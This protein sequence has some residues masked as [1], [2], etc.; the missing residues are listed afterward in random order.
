MAEESLIPERDDV[1]SKHV[2]ISFLHVA[3]NSASIMASRVI[4]FL[5]VI[6]L[7][8]LIARYLSVESFGQL[9]FVMAISIILAP[10]FDLG[11][12]AIVIREIVRNNY[13]AG[14]LIGTILVSKFLLLFLVTAILSIIIYLLNWGENIVIAVFLS[15]FTQSILSYGQLFISVI[16]AFEEM[17]YEIVVNTVHNLILILSTLVVIKYDLGFVP[18]FIASFIGSLSQIIC[19][20]WIVIQKFVVPKFKGI[21]KD[22]ILYYFMEALPLAIFAV[23]LTFAFQVDIF[24]LNAFKGPKDIAMFELAHR[25]VIQLQVIPIAI[26]SSLLPGFTRIANK[27]LD[28]LRAVFLKVIQLLLMISLPLSVLLMFG[29]D[30]IIYNMFG[31][32]Y[33]EAGISLRILAPSLIP[34]FLMYPQGFLL[35]S[36]GKQ[37]LASLSAF[38]C[39]IVNL[40]LDIILIPK[41][42]YIGA[43]ISTAIS[44]SIFF[45]SASYFVFKIIGKIPIWEVIYK[46]LASSIFMGI[47]CYLIIKN[48]NILQLIIGGSLG[49][50]VYV[51]SI[52]IL[53]SKLRN[54]Y[55][56]IE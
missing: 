46:P 26:A 29:S 52:I 35:T 32:K 8:V 45:I 39:F 5:A 33:L 43:S 10:I 3:K 48:N 54:I 49:V 34:L 38:I 11:Y 14:E 12:P 13:Q 1:T 27:S 21:K 16:R 24:I 9:T 44:Y 37:R 53:N 56:R 17:H 40:L 30:S 18:L 23:L 28:F 4:H 55:R 47:V 22:K 20:A 25:I 6:A 2:G 36:V 41:Y 7:N 50:I 19:S 42:G 31:P 51:I 15:L